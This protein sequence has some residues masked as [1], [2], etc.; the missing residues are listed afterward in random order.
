[1]SSF[2]D[3]ASLFSALVLK[4]DRNEFLD[5]EQSLIVFSIF[6]FIDME[7]LRKHFPFKFSG[8]FFISETNLSN[9][10]SLNTMTKLL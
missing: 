5:A 2:L 1:M 4:F 7:F 9:R 3:V 8:V 6:L 10:K